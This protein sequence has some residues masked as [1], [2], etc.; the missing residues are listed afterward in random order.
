MLRAVISPKQ[1]TLT[2]SMAMLIIGFATTVTG[3]G[4]ISAL[5]GVLQTEPDPLTL[6]SKV[7]EA[8]VL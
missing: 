4:M 1:G 6:R 5:L 3:A 2:M 8:T 7:R